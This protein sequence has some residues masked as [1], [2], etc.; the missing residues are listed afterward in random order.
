MAKISKNQLMN[1]FEI[2]ETDEQKIRKRFKPKGLYVTP[3]G[4]AER[5][6]TVDEALTLMYDEAVTLKNAGYFEYD[7][8][9]YKPTKS[10]V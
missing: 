5:I 1:L 4:V 3:K 9:L 10:N 7:G 8:Y 6:M 2:V